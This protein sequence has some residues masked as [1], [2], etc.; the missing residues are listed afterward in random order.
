M[1][2]DAPV[3]PFMLMFATPPSAAEFSVIVYSSF[4][5]SSNGSTIGGGS[6]EASS[7]G[8]LIAGWPWVGRG[9]SVRLKN[10]RSWDGTPIIGTMGT[11]VSIGASSF[12][13]RATR[14]SRVL[15]NLRPKLEFAIRRGLD[16][17]HGFQNVM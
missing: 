8:R 4:F 15:A 10:V 6:V 17:L 16:R 9:V 12:R 14:T 5:F 7:F 2:G 11:R 3:G 1:S 13:A